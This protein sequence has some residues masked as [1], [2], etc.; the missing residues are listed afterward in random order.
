MTL[1]SNKRQYLL[2][3]ILYLYII[4]RKEYVKIFMEV[5][6]F[7]W[8]ILTKSFRRELQK[9]QTTNICDWLFLDKMKT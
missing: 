6:R 4:F 7:V 5:G 1:I 9:V 3:I 8:N 2:T